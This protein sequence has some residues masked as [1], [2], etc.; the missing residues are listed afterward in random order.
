MKM[1]FGHFCGIRLKCDHISDFTF[2]ESLYLPGQRHARHSHERA[3]LC[4]VLQGSFTQTYG[5]NSLECSPAT[6]LYYPAGEAHADTFHN[7]RTRCFV[8]ELNPS[9][10][11]RFNQLSNLINE[12]AS[13]RGGKASGFAL[14][15]FQEVR[16]RDEFSHLSIEG[17][18]LETV[19]EISRGT[20]KVRSGQPTGR[21][22]LVT[23]LVQS[24]LQRPLTLVE[25]ANHAGMHPVSL[26]QAFR[27]TFGCTIGEYVRRLR[28]EFACRELTNQERPISEIAD[29]AG[30]FD[31][32]HFTRTFK[33]FL[34]IT[35][36]EF[37][38]QL[39]SH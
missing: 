4:L 1:P 33:R 27:K 37:R 38:K 30:F 6:L 23:E 16:A 31:Q 14:R 17:L 28:V 9:W 36:A 8:I 39:R 13:F 24:N 29:A 15:V 5:R 32:S 12:P 21:L 10:L 22:E 3:T 34:G 25:I 2:V 18:L 35:P 20:R 11:A 26:A 7:L 19:A